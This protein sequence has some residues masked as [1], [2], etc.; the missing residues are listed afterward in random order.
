M[1]LRVMTYNIQHGHV[2]RSDPGR[3][4][5][6]AMADVIRESGAD[7]IGLNEVRG[8]GERPDYTAQVEQMAAHIGFHC[9]FGCSIRVGGNNPYGNAVLSRFPIAEAKVFH[10][11]DPSAAER[12]GR[13]E[14][15]SILRAVADLPGGERFAVFTSHF[16]LSPAEQRNAVALASALTA[17]ERLPFV[18]M[19][20]FNVAPDDPVLA[21][22]NERLTAANALLGEQYTYLAYLGRYLLSA[23]LLFFWIDLLQISNWMEWPANWC[24][25]HD[26]IGFDQVFWG[27]AVAAFLNLLITGPLNFF[28]N[29]YWAFREKKAGKDI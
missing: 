4:D 20:D 2:H 28:V 11:P 17:G 23:F 8:R 14:H 21:P 22:L 27:K 24:M 19:G 10:I 9:F 25:Q 29:K 26:L 15:R 16:G 7:L 1:K 12:G 3:I 5:P 18:L 13:F 6:A